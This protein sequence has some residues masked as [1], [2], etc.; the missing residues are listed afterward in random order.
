[1][2]T[3]EL[4]ILGIGAGF[5]LRGVIVIYLRECERYANLSLI[6]I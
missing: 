1:M 5:G 4:Y 3:G 6:H 2:K